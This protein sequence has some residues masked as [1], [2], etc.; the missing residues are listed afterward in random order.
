MSVLEVRISLVVE[1][2]EEACQAPKVHVASEP[3]RVRAHRRLHGQH[4]A[5]QGQRI[6]PFAKEVPRVAARKSIRHG[7]YPSSALAAARDS[8]LGLTSYPG[9]PPAHG[10]IRNRRWN[11]A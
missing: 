2:V 6:G 1:V 3:R 7:H 9:P 10:E 8:P 5:A 4:V 11:A